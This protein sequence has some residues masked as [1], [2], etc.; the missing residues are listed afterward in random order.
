M[1]ML[2]KLLILAVIGLATIALYSKVSCKKTNKCSLKLQDLFTLNDEVDE[3]R[4]RV[5]RKQQK[6]ANQ[7][8]MSDIV[9]TNLIDGQ[10]TL[11][12]AIEEL[13]QIN[14]DRAFDYYIESPRVGAT[15]EEEV[16]LY[17]LH[18]AE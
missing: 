2:R 6:L 14:L 16:A 5:Q 18:K 3:R 7:I 8:A 1:R 10:I 11:S 13:H 9:V 17:A 15:R 12:V 4:E